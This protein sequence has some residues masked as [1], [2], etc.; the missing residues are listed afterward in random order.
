MQGE[1]DTLNDVFERFLNDAGVFKDRDVLRHEYLPGRL[2]HREEQVKN[3]GMV[4]APLLRENRCS[5][6]FIYGETGTGKTAVIK[7][8][9]QRLVQKAA[10]V[11]ACVRTAYVNCRLVGTEYRAFKKIC[12]ALNIHVPFTGLAVGEVFD[13]LKDGLENLQISLIVVLDELDE[14]IKTRGNV[15]LYELTRVNESLD[16]SAVSIVGISNDLRFRELLESRVLSSLSEE[17]V[18]FNPYNASELQDILSERADLA[19]SN[20]KLHDG[21]LSL[22]AA[23]AASQHGDA[24]RALDL[25]RVAGEVAERK[26]AEGITEEHVREAERRI[27]HDR[28]IEAIRNLT[29]HSKLALHSVHLIRK[30]G[31]FSSITGDIYQVY[32][33]ICGELGISALT[34]RRVSTLIS[35]LDSIGLLNSTVISRGR[36]GRTKKT[37]LAISRR[38]LKEA[39]SKDNHLGQ[40]NGFTPTCL[41]LKPTK[42]T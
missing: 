22:C 38:A 36:Y 28:V 1:V 16:G 27:E 40:L 10:E 9:L 21:A 24:R 42:L 14:M 30:A 19:F 31:I 4:V 32:S 18:L 20:G 35:E 5:N 33:E 11:G 23:L 6:I 25:L 41:K 15:L 3:V 12:D 7:F 13:R 8:V 29:I 17:E 34:Q 39:Y 37:S 26:N 2:P